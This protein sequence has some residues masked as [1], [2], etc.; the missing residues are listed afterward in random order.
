M[1][2]TLANNICTLLMPVYKYGI[3]LFY[4]YLYMSI[5]IYIYSHTLERDKENKIKY[6]RILVCLE[7]SGARRRRKGSVTA[8]ALDNHTCA[9][10][11]TT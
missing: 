9:G 2:F 1:I 6:P 8:L 3:A 10:F 11:L 5:S 4:I 7:S